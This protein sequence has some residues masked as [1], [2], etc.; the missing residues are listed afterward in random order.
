M[1]KELRLYSG[2]YDFVADSLIASIDELMGEEVT[3]RVNSTGGSVFANYGICAKM[4]EHGNV[5]IK[6]DG[7]AMSSAANLLPYAKSVSCLDVSTFL[8]HRADMMVENDGDKE[9]LARINKD[10][11]S[12]LLLKVDADKFEKVTGTTIEDMFNAE[13]RVDVILTAK[14]AKQIGLVN[15]IINL[16]PAE[17]NALNNVYSLAANNEQNKKTNMNL[18]KLKAEHPALYNEVLALGI[19]QEKDRVGSFMAFVELD[20]KA[21]KEG[22]TSGKAMTETERSEFAIKAVSTKQLSNIVADSTPSEL[23]TKEQIELDAKSAKE[24]ELLAFSKAVDK[25][26]G[27]N[28]TV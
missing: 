1:S 5:N 27:L 21:V 20:A 7:T 8:L 25:N 23:K 19:A 24:L 22:I 18:E 14:Q 13:K 16:T 15:T 9:F 10:L 26:L 12:K 6:V 11:K 17:V 4:M 2:I 3:L 28:K